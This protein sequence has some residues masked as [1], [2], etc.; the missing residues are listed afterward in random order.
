ML[1]ISIRLSLVWIDWI[2][3]V[4][5]TDPQIGFMV[6]VA[7]ARVY[8]LRILLDTKFEHISWYQISKWN[9]LVIIV[10]QTL[11]LKLTTHV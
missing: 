10:H 1:Q 8:G 5:Q 3:L 9:R 6:Y 4:L 11:R 2:S 7:K